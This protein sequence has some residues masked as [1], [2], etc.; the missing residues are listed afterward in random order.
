[1]NFFLE[2]MREPYGSRDGDMAERRRSGAR[3]RP[4]HRDARTGQGGARKPTHE[5]GGA[6]RISRARSAWNV[7]Y[8]LLSVEDRPPLIHELLLEARIHDHD[9]Y[10]VSKA[11]EHA[12]VS[13]RHLHR[14]CMQHL[15]YPPGTVIDLAR[16]VS[17]SVDLTTTNDRLYEIARRH[18]FRRHSDMN[19]FFARFSAFSP[20]QFRLRSERPARSPGRAARPRLNATE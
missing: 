10:P 17:I 18:G 6:E 3:G 4:G 13:V 12:G 1:M 15:G 19:R 2:Q 9:A 14:L 8:R 7:R 11:A 5:D 16:A 20:R